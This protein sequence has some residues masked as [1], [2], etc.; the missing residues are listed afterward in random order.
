M[1]NDT[2]TRRRAVNL[3]QNDLQNFAQNGRNLFLNHRFGGPLGQNVPPQNVPP[4]NVPPQNVPPQNVPP[5]NWVPNQRPP[6]VRDGIL[7]Q[8]NTRRQAKEKQMKELLG[9]VM[10][11]VREARQFSLDVYSQ[12]AQAKQEDP[13]S[14]LTL[15]L[16][17]FS[18]DVE[19]LAKELDQHASTVRSK[20]ENDLDGAITAI[21]L[22][23]ETAKKLLDMAP[24]FRKIVAEHG[25]EIWESN[26][27]ETRSR[28]ESDLDK[29]IERHRPTVEQALS[30]KSE[31]QAVIEKQTLVQKVWTGCLKARKVPD[32]EATSQLLGASVQHSR[33]IAPIQQRWEEFQSRFVQYKRL[34]GQVEALKTKD[35]KTQK[36]VLDTRNVAHSSASNANWK[37]AD[38]RLTEAVELAKQL[39]P[40]N[41]SLAL[42]FDKEWG[43]LRPRVERA[44]QLKTGCAAIDDGVKDLGEYRDELLKAVAEHDFS[45]ADYLLSLTSS[46]ANGLLADAEK[47]DEL[48]TERQKHAGVLTAV[49]KLK[50]S[51]TPGPAEQRFTQA[52]ASFEQEANGGFFKRAMSNL[53]IAIASGEQWLLQA[54]DPETAGYYK[55]RDA[56]NADLVAAAK[57]VPKYQPVRDAKQ[58]F[59]EGMK[60]LNKAVEQGDFKYARQAVEVAGSRAWNLLRLDQQQRTYD[61]TLANMQPTL[62]QA[63]LVNQTIPGIPALQL[64]LSNEMQAAQNATD[65]NLVTAAGLLKPAMKTASRIV[66]TAGTKQRQD[67]VHGL[68]GPTLEKVK[69][70]YLPTG[71]A[72][73]YAKKG[74]QT[75]F[76]QFVLA[77]RNYEQNRNDANA[78]D[79]VARAADAYLRVHRTLDEG[80]QRQ[81]P[82]RDRQ[83]ICETTLKQIAHLKLA[84]EFD[85]VGPPPWTPT[86]E[87][88]IGQLRTEVAFEEGCL[89][90]ESEKGP[91]VNGS[92][93]INNIE[94]GDTPEENKKRKQ[95]LFKPAK[96]ENPIPGFPVGG[97]AAR[98]V[99]GKSV[100]DSLRE[101]TGLEFGV[102]DTYMITVDGNRIKGQEGTGLLVGSAQVFAP[103]GGSLL[104]ACE[105]DPSILTRVSKKSNQKMALLDIVMLQTDRNSGNF[106]LGPP[107]DTGG[108]TL[109]P[110]DNGLALPPPLG[111]SLRA[112]R[113][114][115]KGNMVLEMPGADEKF[116]DELQASI[117]M[118]D[119]NE[120]EQ[121]LVQQ[122]QTL[123]QQNPTL[124]VDQLVSDA[125]ILASKRSA[126]FLKFAA[127]DLTIREI[128]QTLAAEN[129]TLLTCS[130]QNMPQVFADAVANAK[131]R[132][133]AFREVATYSKS[134]IAEMRR[135]LMGLGWCQQGGLTAF[136]EWLETFGPDALRWYKA[137][138]ENPA[139][140]QELDQT[141]KALG[142]PPTLLAKLKGQT[143][144]EKVELARAAVEELDPAGSRA[145]EVDELARQLQI[146]T[147]D[148]KP[149]VRKLLLD[150]LETFPKN[151]AKQ[152]NVDLKLD[153]RQKRIAI[154]NRLLQEVPNVEGL[155]RQLEQNYP[156]FDWRNSIVVQINVK[157]Y[158]E[159]QRVEKQ[160]GT[161]YQHLFDLDERG[162]LALSRVNTF[163]DAVRV[164]LQWKKFQELG[165]DMALGKAGVDVADLPG[166]KMRL[167]TLVGLESQK[168]GSRLF[169]QKFAN[170]QPEENVLGG[171]ASREVEQ[172]LAQSFTLPIESTG[173]T[174][175]TK[176]DMNRSRFV[177][178]GMEITEPGA[179][180]FKMGNAIGSLN[181]A[182]P[183]QMLAAVSQIA[184]QGMLLEMERLLQNGQGPIPEVPVPVPESENSTYE[185]DVLPSGDVKVTGRTSRNVQKLI[186]PK[187]G[188]LRD[189]SPLSVFS[190]SY[191]VTLAQHEVQQGKPVPH[192]GPIKFFVNIL[193]A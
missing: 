45:T 62:T 63:G 46:R 23:D 11:L 40:D 22:A 27:P 105:K 74:G 97:A 13:N 77:L 189:V 164:L 50:P 168:V 10:P 142:N 130:D 100:S 80:A 150:A 102:P 65:Q 15:E 116:D 126:Q 88:R 120:I 42:T 121:K 34:F 125:S 44:M 57:V 156:M 53:R 43:E 131:R 173:I 112:Q 117:E 158:D 151:T 33:L 107:D 51:Q 36:Q 76:D 1:S 148:L 67:N 184:N 160:A 146:D 99:L 171:M 68:L 66:G 190:F 86:Q 169:D 20:A 55:E 118:L 103:S 147:K 108:P 155:H 37:I 193:P 166:L 61:R 93:W 133:A 187:S 174:A 79:A 6:Q 59:D 41:G 3:G 140:R 29:A 123:A 8:Q 75:E 72:D 95:L 92:Y 152:L 73:N 192:V 162:E 181:N 180:D 128:Y 28:D 31:C 137:R 12:K 159:L 54:T 136:D 175:Q 7:S 38:E 56:A 81:S 132:S 101:M 94:W 178:N 87:G 122:R 91:G 179:D 143:L 186:D 24:E 191:S 19:K 14:K 176:K 96:Q 138:I 119:P 9:I 153:F 4:Q 177:L 26:A 129:V 165:G 124:Q 18:S 60:D 163:E 25:G 49:L 111:L 89:Q 52:W 182:M 134:E 139:V 106:M 144:M 109:I 48:Q 115:I 170:A 64:Q 84:A 114:M 110:I 21:G 69:K 188:N 141:L 154:A 127:K 83:E 78:R 183:A 113:G 2:R 35:T 85:Q 161:T 58:D 157:Y 17:A 185:I 167:E 47:W 5:Q 172:N 82:A 39:L 71:T 70:T 90:G 149:P 145:G 32:L 30:V 16:T 104:S 98:E 135:V